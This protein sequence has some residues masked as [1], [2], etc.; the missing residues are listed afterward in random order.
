MNVI[1]HEDHGR[2]FAP[3]AKHVAELSVAAATENEI[4]HDS[5]ISIHNTPH[6]SLGIESCPRSNSC[7]RVLP[8]NREQS[9][10]AGEVWLLT[11]NRHFLSSETPCAA[12]RSKS[13]FL[14]SQNLKS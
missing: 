11:P 4:G 3:G 9:G 6:L 14:Q 7:P 13:S 12:V 8:K 5:K 10:C 1:D 2:A